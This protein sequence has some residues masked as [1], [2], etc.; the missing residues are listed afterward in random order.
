VSPPIASPTS[1]RQVQTVER[2][3]QQAIELLEKAVD[4]S[5]RRS[6]VRLP[7]AFARDQVNEIAS[8]PLAKMLQGGGEVRLKVLLTMLMIATKHPHEARV[9]SRDLAAMLNL[10]DPDVAGARRVNK[11]LGDLAAVPLI[12]RE[13]RPGHVPNTTILDPGGSGEEWNT[14]QLTGTTYIT[15]PPDLWRRGWLIALSGRALAMLIVLREI[16]A[17]R[18]KGAWVPG[19]RHRQYGLSEDTWT[20]A[21]KELREWGLLDVD[22]KVTS[23]HGEPRRR[24]VYT[25]HLDRLGMFDPGDLTLPT[26][27]IMSMR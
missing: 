27:P 16:T 13:H 20:K 17:G 2:P 19:T 23:F 6:S 9:S 7:L 10:R 26:W 22:V 24:N 15:L 12:R 3:P 8:P 14:E 18:E 1:E 4:R 5:K 25:L 21:T 11:A